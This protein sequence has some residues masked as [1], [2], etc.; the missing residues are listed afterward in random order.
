MN[1]TINFLLTLRKNNYPQKSLHRCIKHISLLSLIQ[2]LYHQWT[3]KRRRNFTTHFSAFKNRP[4]ISYQP[5][6]PNL[7]Y[8][9]LNIGDKILIIKSFQSPYDSGDTRRNNCETLSL[10]F[11][12]ALYTSPRWRKHQYGSKKHSNPDESD[13]VWPLLPT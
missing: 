7:L 1:P 5:S 12:F 11:T 10:N 13:E 3:L 6:F 2:V 4:L 9:H 8:P